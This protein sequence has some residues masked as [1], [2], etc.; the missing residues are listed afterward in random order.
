MLEQRTLPVSI[1]PFYFLYAGAWI[2]EALLTLKV[3]SQHS[4]SL[5]IVRDWLVSIHFICKRTNP[6]PHSHPL[7]YLAFIL[8]A[9]ISLS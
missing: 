9:T 2:S 6:K 8:Q 5:E 1:I 7:R 3:S 4:Q